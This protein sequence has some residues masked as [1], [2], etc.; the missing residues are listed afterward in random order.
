MHYLPALAAVQHEATRCISG[1][2]EDEIPPF[3]STIHMED[4]SLSYTM[5]G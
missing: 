4:R 3:A 2:M 5:H 1:I